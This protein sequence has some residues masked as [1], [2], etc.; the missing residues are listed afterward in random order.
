MTEFA[1]NLP[2]LETAKSRFTTLGT[3]AD[4]MVTLAEDA[5]P[6]F[7]TW[8]LAGLPFSAFYGDLAHQFRDRMGQVADSLAGHAQRIDNCAEAY[9]TKEADTENTIAE[10]NR[11]VDQDPDF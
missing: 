11:N 4:N 7:Y 10:A 8:G 2:D 9:R 5:D 6:D 3:D 1:V